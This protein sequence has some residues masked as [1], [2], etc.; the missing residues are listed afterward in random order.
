MAPGEAAGKRCR[1][2]HRPVQIELLLCSGF[3]NVQTAWL[4]H[5]PLKLSLGCTCA[6]A[7]HHGT[8]QCLQK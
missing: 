1:R 5:S 8:Q 2:S 7:C 3:A 4:F 6:C